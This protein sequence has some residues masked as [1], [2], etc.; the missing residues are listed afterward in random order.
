MLGACSENSDVCTTLVFYAY[1]SKPGWTRFYGT[2]WVTDSEGEPLK[3][4][5]LFA[6]AM[7]PWIKHVLG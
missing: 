5:S 4:F 7:P 1:P 6:T 3:S 2:S